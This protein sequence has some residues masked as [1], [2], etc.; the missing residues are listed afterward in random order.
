MSI[1]EQ[2][3]PARN[4]V[5]AEERLIIAAG[6]LLGEVGPN[7]MSVRNVAERAGVNHGLV[8]HYFGGKDGLL[9]AA[10][11]R[12]VQE[13][14]VFA[15]E[16]SHGDPIPT[17][18]L[19]NHDPK[20]L[21]AVVRAVL[22]DEMQLAT[23]EITE[24]V[25]VPQGAMAHATKSKNISEPDVQMKAMVAVAMAME[26]GWAALEPFL[27][28]VTDVVED[29]QEEVRDIVRTFRRQMVTQVLQ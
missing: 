25:S 27:F 13:H 1:S 15:K 10:M 23:T 11:T 20:Y 26:M 22:D 5:D 21:R 2:S 12:L 24:G 28:A 18:L 16:A 14:A 8:H 4:R 9:K 17:P 7:S 3:R 19:L 6:E 29:E